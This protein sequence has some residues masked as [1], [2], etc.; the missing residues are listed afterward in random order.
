MQA[1]PGG[2]EKENDVSFIDVRPA[3]STLAIA[4][5]VKLWRCRR[6]ERGI[7]GT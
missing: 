3:I 5:L 6:T 7:T 2:Q 4:P 1:S